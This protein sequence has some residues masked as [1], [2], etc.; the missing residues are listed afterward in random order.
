MNKIFY[1]VVQIVNYVCIFSTI[2]YVKRKK[3][4]FYRVK[5]LKKQEKVI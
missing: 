4:S 5:V 2:I 1:I 3:S